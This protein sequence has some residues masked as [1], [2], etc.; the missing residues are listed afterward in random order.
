MENAKGTCRPHPGRRRVIAAGRRPAGQAVPRGPGLLRSRTR[1]RSAFAAASL[2]PELHEPGQVGGLEGQQAQQ[3]GRLDLPR[4]ES[5]D[6]MPEGPRQ[7]RLVLGRKSRDIHRRAYDE[8]LDQPHATALLGGHFA[9][10]PVDSFQLQRVTVEVVE[11]YGIE[12]LPGDLHRGR[13]APR[14]R[15][16]DGSA[17]PEARRHGENPI[18]SEMQGGGEG[19]R[20]AD[21]AVAVPAV[22]QVH[23]GE[24]EGECRRGEHVIER[25][26][27]VPAASVGP[28]P[29]AQI[30]AL[31]PH[32][33]LSGP[34][35]A[36]QQGERPETSLRDVLGDA[37][38]VPVARL[39]DVRQRPAQG[40]R[41][42]QALDGRRQPGAARDQAQAPPDDQTA[43]R[44]AVGA[45]DA[46]G[47]QVAPEVEQ[48]VH[49]LRL[50]A[51]VRREERGVDG[52]GRDAGHDG[53]VGVGDVSRDPAQ[54]AD[55]VG[56]AGAAAGQEN[57][58]VVGAAGPVRPR[59]G[60]VRG[61]GLGQVVGVHPSA[62]GEQAR[63]VSHG[64]RCERVERARSAHGDR[65]IAGW[66]VVRRV[67]PRV[68]SA[69][70]LLSRGPVG[71]LRVDPDG[72]R[73]AGVLG[74][75][76]AVDVRGDPA[77]CWESCAGGLPV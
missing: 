74:G 47:G 63:I 40:R 57:R 7:L 75:K 25:Q 60:G 69:L 29:F 26:R 66:R 22:R 55:L 27:G 34:V 17:R 31:G 58:Q 10:Q 38:D 51:A 45:E 9:E 13:V 71:R 61:I 76:V 72:A 32:H 6:Q 19:R 42:D 12:K 70:R 23:G 21:A 73:P 64:A 53:K 24:E 5:P 11:K 54:E 1:I 62:R 56:A 3:V 39:E 43:E 15:I 33:R 65:W 18:R 8:E 67:A 52:A 46:F 30:A 16:V 28:L 50:G 20:Q 14:V 44:G 68:G 77:P 37:G 36:G 48:P 4:S 49:R 59:P 2:S 41:I 35:V